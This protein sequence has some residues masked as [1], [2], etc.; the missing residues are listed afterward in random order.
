M[1]R[2]DGETGEGLRASDGGGRT[3]N[4]DLIQEG[5][6]PRS[7]GRAPGVRASDHLRPPE[8]DLRILRILRIVVQ[9]TEYRQFQC[10]EYKNESSSSDLFFQ[11]VAFHP[12]SSLCV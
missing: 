10:F 3:P 4:Q 11:F 8:R 5:F 1:I 12:V 7:V 9:T 2:G 6:R